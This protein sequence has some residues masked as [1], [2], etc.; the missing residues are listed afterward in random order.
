MIFD[1]ADL[2]LIALPRVTDLPV[3]GEVIVVVPGGGSVMTGTASV[4]SGTMWCEPGLEEDCVL[5]SEKG[6]CVLWVIMVALGIVEL[7]I[8]VASSRGSDREYLAA[9]GFFLT[10]GVDSED[11]SVELRERD[12][13]ISGEFFDLKCL[14]LTGLTALEGNCSG[15]FIFG[16]E[17]ELNLLGLEDLYFGRLT[18]GSEGRDLVE[19]GKS[20][21]VV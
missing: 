13:L 9:S 20:V 1:F 10:D 16:I 19:E 21:D 7:S 18:E 11:T 14:L 6:C 5:G 3:Y 8:E 15:G 4:I 12:D 17:V 2:L